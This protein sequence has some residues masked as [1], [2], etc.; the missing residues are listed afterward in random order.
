M[1]GWSVLDVVLR[2]GSVAVCTQKHERKK[3]VQLQRE[4]KEGKRKK[5]SKVD[6]E[7]LMVGP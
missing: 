3:K 1:E 6:T 7:L 2:E 4:K 5:T